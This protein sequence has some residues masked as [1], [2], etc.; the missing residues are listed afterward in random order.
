MGPSL[1]RIWSP[2]RSS[3]MP[4]SRSRRGRWSSPQA[5]SLSSSGRRHS[6]RRQSSRFT[7]RSN[8]G[9]KKRR[10]R[11]PSTR[12]LVCK[13]LTV[14][15]KLQFV[16]FCAQYSVDKVLS[17]AGENVASTQQYFFF[18]RQTLSPCR[19]IL[20]DVHFRISL[21]KIFSFPCRWRRCSAGMLNDFQTVGVR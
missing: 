1:R 5:H 3:P 2:R 10:S 7:T 11:M 17:A 21:V 16:M 20:G 19:C 15:R 9:L 13:G 14:M 8:P 4:R 6:G 12:S 18:G